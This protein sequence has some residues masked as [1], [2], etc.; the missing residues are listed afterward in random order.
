MV[1]LNNHNNKDSN[2][3]KYEIVGTY[4]LSKF[5]SK[6]KFQDFSLTDPVTPDWILKIEERIT[7]WHESFH[8]MQ[9]CGTGFGF[10]HS[11]LSLNRDIPTFID[12]LK[13]C[14]E[15]SNISI[16]L[17]SNINSNYKSHLKLKSA[18]RRYDNSCMLIE[19]L[20]K[21]FRQFELVHVLEGTA[22]LLDVLNK[23]YFLLMNGY[24]PEDSVELYDIDGIKRTIENFSIEY[25]HS[26]L[27]FYNMLKNEGLSPIQ[28]CSLFFLVSDLA[29][30][31]PP[32]TSQICSSPTERFVTLVQTI[33]ENLD[34]APIIPQD[35]FVPNLRIEKNGLI[36]DF[37][38]H[39]HNVMLLIKQLRWTQKGTK[40]NQDGLL[41]GKR[42]VLEFAN[43]LLT[44]CGYCSIN[45]VNT[46]WLE[47][48]ESFRKSIK[49]IVIYPYLPWFKRYLAFRINNPQMF[50]GFSNIRKTVY[51][52]GTPF[53]GTSKSGTTFITHGKIADELI[54]E[55][56]GKKINDLVNSKPQSNFRSRFLTSVLQ[57]PVMEFAIITEIVKDMINSERLVCPIVQDNIIECKVRNKDCKKGVGKKSKHK[58]R[59]NC[60]F[61]K[62][63]WKYF[64]KY[65]HKLLVA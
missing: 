56:Y 31:I 11:I 20:F 1:K 15:E 10:L 9:N 24:L 39:A 62:T 41:E 65:P 21:P 19:E 7:A 60:F 34:S 2:L 52:I 18:I 47:F 26:F 33:K 55:T 23:R 45:E 16:P 53:I 58:G 46:L 6:V 32:E 44:N 36:R 29:L 63:F 42:Q 49:D 54:R 64:R 17:R 14:R 51:F 12:I 22:G 40:K 48:F 50:W 35:D 37:G 57:Y 4:F 30:H 27:Y 5:C 38:G 13:L 43:N 61:V 28:F 8:C 59:D 25:K 3:L